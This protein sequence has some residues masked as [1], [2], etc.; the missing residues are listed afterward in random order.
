MPFI[1]HADGWQKPRVVIYGENSYPP[2]SFE[3]DGKPDGIYY[4]ILKKATQRMP[5]YDVKFI[6]LPWKRILDMAEHGNLFAFFPPYYR[7]KHRPYLSEYSHPIYTEETIVC[8]KTLHQPRRQWPQDYR[9]LRFGNQNGYL[10]GKGV[11]SDLAEKGLI[12]LEETNGLP[13]NLRKL[14]NN[15]IDCLITDK[16]ALTWTLTNVIGEDSLS[17]IS[18]EVTLDKE[19]GYVAYSGKYDAPYRRDFIDTLNEI[20]ID[21]HSSGEIQAIATSVL[22]NR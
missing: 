19:N 8:C 1:A 17:Q 11:L 22:E 21:M 10:A 12:E 5:D 15:R 7:P 3:V 2:Y 4:R 16:D 20:I 18:I 13:A 14:L 9:H 6:M